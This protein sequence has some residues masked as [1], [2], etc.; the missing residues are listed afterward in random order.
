MSELKRV[1]E[2]KRTLRE[3]AEVLR[4]RLTKEFAEREPLAYLHL[5]KL[6]RDTERQIELRKELNIA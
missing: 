6:L 5:S 1:S 4:S 3:R 2:L